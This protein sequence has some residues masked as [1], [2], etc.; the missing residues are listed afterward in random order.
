VP[1][2]LKNTTE[3]KV[4]RIYVK[5]VIREKKEREK[6][7]GG[8][9]K[10]FSLNF[11]KRKMSELRFDG[12]VVIVTG[13]GGGKRLIPI[14]ILSYPIISYPKHSILHSFL[15]STHIMR[16][17]FPFRNM[18]TRNYNL[19]PTEPQPKSNPQNQIRKNPTR[20]NLISYSNSKNRSW[21][22][23]YQ[24]S[25]PIRSNLCY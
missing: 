19:I 18:L 11:A 22:G 24:R 1:S 10:K 7:D 5:R 23:K 13:A 21:K 16:P 17:C 2:V 3:E 9:K 4:T 6:R 12:R 15:H 8:A 25:V 20:S 14:L